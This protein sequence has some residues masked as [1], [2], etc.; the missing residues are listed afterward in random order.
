[1]LSS[2]SFAGVEL[3]ELR[4]HISYLT[5]DRFLVPHTFTQVHTYT[6]NWTFWQIFI[7][8]GD[9]GRGGGIK[10]KDQGS[11]VTM[12]YSVPNTT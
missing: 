7:S 10:E 11:G 6:H 5:L 1:M 12:C 2:K 9:W 8:L 3:M 4:M